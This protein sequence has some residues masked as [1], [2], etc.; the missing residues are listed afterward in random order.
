MGPVKLD[1]L[2]VSRRVNPAWRLLASPHA[3]AVIPFADRAFLAPGVRTVPEA[4]LAIALQDVL[5]GRG[6]TMVRQRQESGAAR[7]PGGRPSATDVSGSGPGGRTDQP[8]R[9]AAGPGVT[10]VCRALTPCPSVQRT[11]TVTSAPQSPRSP[12]S[13]SPAQAAT[14]SAHVRRRRP[15]TGSPTNNPARRAAE[16][17]PARTT[18]HVRPGRRHHAV[19][20][21]RRPVASGRSAA[22][23][24]RWDSNPRWD[25][26]KGSASACW[27]TGAGELLAGLASRRY[28]PTAE[29]S[30]RQRGRTR[31]WGR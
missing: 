20:R 6:L 24:P 3:P 18:R 7:G 14:G 2:V 17:A 9:T 15:A 5:E 8:L 21:S 26:F 12:G 29:L 10:T 25:P 16:G 1:D 22:G 23:C 19:R 28:C 27:A 13:S 31:P 11:W 4:T 30:W